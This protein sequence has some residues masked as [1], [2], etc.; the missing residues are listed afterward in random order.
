MRNIYHY[1]VRGLVVLSFLGIS[2]WVT[3]TARSQ[4]TDTKTTNELGQVARMPASTL[5]NYQ[6]LLLDTNGDPISASLPI[7]FRL[8]NMGTGGTPCWEEAHTVSATN[9]L[10]QALLGQTVPIDAACLAGDAY[11]E[12]VVNGETL[13]PR[14]LLTSVAY[15][16]ESSTLAAGANTQGS[17]SLGGN[18]NVQGFDVLNVGDISA[19]AGNTVLTLSNEYGTVQ[20]MSITDLILVIDSDNNA[21]GSSF[22]FIKDNGSEVFRINENGSIIG[23]G[24]LDLTSNPLVGIST[25]TAVSNGTSRI[26]GN[27]QVGNNAWVPAFVPMDGNDLAVEGT[28]EQGGSGGARFFQVGIGTDPLGGGSNEGT[29]TTSGAAQ[30]GGTIDATGHDIINVDTITYG[31]NQ[32]IASTPSNLR[33]VADEGLFAVFL[34]K[35]N[36]ETGEKFEIIRD[37]GGY[38][39]PRKII[40]R[41]DE[42]GQI[43]WPDVSGGIDDDLLIQGDI[44]SPANADLT[45]D[46]GD[47]TFNT[48]TLHDDVYVSGNLTI[49][50]MCNVAQ[51]R[52]GESDI[53]QISAGVSQDCVAGSITSGAYVEANLLTPAQRS[54]G[55]IDEFTLG[56]LLCWSAEMQALNRCVVANDRLVMAV[57]DR[58]GKPIVLGAELV[59]VLGPVQAGDILVASNV[60][61][62]AMVNNNPA[63]GTVIGQALQDLVGERGLIKTM[64]RKW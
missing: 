3:T 6:G 7:I 31:A 40:F 2:L 30:F 50:G 35:N 37:A 46:A 28:L 51:N 44:A 45:I 9:G 32:V 53:Q 34:D 58:Q 4:T 55:Q 14:E 49:G 38:V 52:P 20:A 54:A 62:Y 8:Y 41:V 26:E 33:M 17:L 21:T 22:Q 16:V 5:F 29:L 64:I 13:M 18:L 57:A 36:N 12:L 48:L 24:Q 15:A 39:A 23:Y 60:P 61:G 10:F 56:D 42:A 47:G 11:L 63:P 43:S 25:L 27:L 59:K 19:D 1:F